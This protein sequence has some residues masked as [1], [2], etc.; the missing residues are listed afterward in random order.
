[1]RCDDTK[2]SKLEIRTR[3]KT[4]DDEICGI[5]PVNNPINQSMQQMKKKNN[6]S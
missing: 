3:A 6:L 5:T 1:M 2:M 4:A